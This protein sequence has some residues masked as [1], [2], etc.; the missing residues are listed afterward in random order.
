VSLS[1][2]LSL[3]GT[4]QPHLRPRSHFC[5]IQRD[6]TVPTDMLLCPA[7]VHPRHSVQCFGDLKTWCRLHVLSKIDT[8]MGVNWSSRKSSGYRTLR[9]RLENV[10][11]V[12]ALPF[13][14]N[15]P[16]ELCQLLMR[17]S[18]VPFSDGFI[19]C[20]SCLSL[21]V[22]RLSRYPDCHTSCKK[23]KKTSRWSCHLT[24][25]RFLH[26]PS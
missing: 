16:A 7:K 3:R 11:L 10:D 15:C 14:L 17:S 18:I 8:A 2:E 24:A 12:F 9:R 23:R 4:S 5:S 13:L 21:H 6:L 26:S 20:L 1:Y 19:P 25:C 22:N